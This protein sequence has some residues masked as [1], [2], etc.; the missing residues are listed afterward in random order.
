MHSVIK[1][2]SQIG[3]ES[4]SQLYATFKRNT[5]NTVTPKKGW[6]LTN[7]SE[8]CKLMYH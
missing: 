5:Q 8:S 2:D 1:I 4:K 7:K 6:K 3:L